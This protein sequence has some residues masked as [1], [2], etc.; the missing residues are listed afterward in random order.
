MPWEFMQGRGTTKIQ[1]GGRH[2]F[3]RN[4][5]MIEVA[6]TGNGLIWAP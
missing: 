5:P 6:L 4:D 2:V 3:N 1:V